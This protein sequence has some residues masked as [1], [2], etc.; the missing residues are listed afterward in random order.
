MFLVDDDI[1]VVTA[2]DDATVSLITD[3]SMVQQM[4]SSFVFDG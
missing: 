1:V 4:D 2:E 3:I